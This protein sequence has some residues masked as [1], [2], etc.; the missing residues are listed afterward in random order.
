M[1]PE[2]T[3]EFQ[4]R[5]VKGRSVDFEST[6]ENWNQYKL[7]DGSV[8]KIK[9][10]LMEVMRLDHYSDNGDPTYQFVAQQIVAVQVADNLK[11]K[12]Q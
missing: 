10:V 1:G 2:K 12:A 11:R 7:E 8:L 9:T 3:V 4:G 5:Q 6:G